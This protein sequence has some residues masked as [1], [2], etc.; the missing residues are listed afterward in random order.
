MCML[1]E[2]L[3]LWSRAIYSAAA[4]MFYGYFFL[5]LSFFMVARYL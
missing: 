5:F 2:M 1:Y 4:I 3:L